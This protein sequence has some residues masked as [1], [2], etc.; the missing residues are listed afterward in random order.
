MKTHT[1]KLR[2][3]HYV[4]FALL[5]LLLSGA[6]VVAWTFLIEPARLVTHEERIA[7]KEWHAGDLRVAVIADLHVGAP[8]ISIDKLRK[9][10]AR[11]NDLNPD[12]IVLP[13]DFVI[14][15]VVGG[16]FIEPELIADELKNLHAR[17][18]VYAVLGNH[19][20]WEGGERIRDAIQSRGIRVLENEAVELDATRK[21]WLV[22]LADLWTRKVDQD[23]PLGQI[24]TDANVLAFAHN[25]DIFVDTSPRI[26]L[27]I[28]GHTHGGQVNLPFYGRP[29]SVSKYGDRFAS[30]LI[31][32]NGRHLFVSTGIGT[33]S[34]PGR[35]R[36]PPE[37]NVLTVSGS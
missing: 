11:T 35:F 13:G 3:R 27:L 26:N 9:I 4:L 6:A 28:C 16:K 36:V 8:H 19:D 25:P 2:R 30:G 15:G 21:L 1:T 32:E 17:Y 5:A 10:V 22:G 23:T 20:W 18:G 14:T 24:P 37:I 31:I 7:I 12:L 33:S 29:V 34:L